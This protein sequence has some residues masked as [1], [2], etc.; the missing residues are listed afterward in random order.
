VQ[1][2]DSLLCDAARVAVLLVE[3]TSQLVFILGDTSY[4]RYV[5]SLPGLNITA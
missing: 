2:P 3:E 5:V 4:G 1:F